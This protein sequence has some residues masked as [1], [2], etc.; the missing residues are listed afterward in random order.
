MTQDSLTGYRLTPAAQSDLE[1]IWRYTAHN[2]SPKQADSYIDTLENTFEHLLTMP[3]MA[4]ERGEFTPPVRVHPNGK[5][6]IIYRIEV[7]HLL[8]LRILGGRQDWLAV[9][10]AIDQ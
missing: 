5:H 2:W 7:D 3:E 10:Q 9:L 4:R 6:L 8:I 1:D